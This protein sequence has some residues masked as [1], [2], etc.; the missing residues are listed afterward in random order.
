MLLHLFIVAQIGITAA[1]SC[2]QPYNMYSP[3]YCNSYAPLH[4]FPMFSALILV[5]ISFLSVTVLYEPRIYV[6]LTQYL[7]SICSMIFCAIYLGKKSYLP[8]TL[9]RRLFI[10]YLHIYCLYIVHS[11]H[12]QCIYIFRFCM[13]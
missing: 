1:G 10:C 3:E 12:Y 2:H 11:I 6:V 7:I 13:L 4:V 8:Y 9:F 5:T